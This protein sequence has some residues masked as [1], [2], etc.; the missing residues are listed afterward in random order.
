LGI[1]LREAADS[2]I[3]VLFSHRRR[4][5][6]KDFVFPRAPKNRSNIQTRLLRRDVHGSVFGECQGCSKS[7][8]SRGR[9][10][11]CISARSSR[12]RFH[13]SALRRWVC[14]TVFLFGC[15][16]SPVWFLAP[17]FTLYLKSA[18]CLLFFILSR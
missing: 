17:H 18:I 3:L 13:P 1:G 7:R 5:E 10:P 11:R 6:H 16:L 9:G 8:E 15:H 2:F 4:T 12:E 14:P